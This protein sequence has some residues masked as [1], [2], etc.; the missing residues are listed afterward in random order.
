[1][2][3]N[4]IIAFLIRM[5]RIIDEVSELFDSSQYSVGDYTVMLDGLDR[6]SSP[7]VLQ[8][9]ITPTPLALSSSPHANARPALRQGGVVPWAR[10]T[11]STVPP[12]APCPHAMP[13][14]NA[15]APQCDA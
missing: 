1:M 11:Q 4:Q 13:P 14:R 12:R 3:R 2:C 9:P 15:A 7:D 10:S 6:S 5:R 8:V